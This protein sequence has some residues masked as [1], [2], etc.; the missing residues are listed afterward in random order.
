MSSIMFI[1]ANDLFRSPTNPRKHFDERQLEELASTIRKVGILQ[2]LLVRKNDDGYEV[3]FGSRRY[4]AGI[5][6]GLEVFPCRVVEMTDEQVLEAQAIENLQRSDLQPLEEADS[7]KTLLE[8]PE[9]DVPAIAAKVGKSESYI[10]Q[11]LKLLELCDEGRTYLEDEVITVSHAIMLARLQP[12]DQKAALEHIVYSDW[13]VPN[14]KLCKNVR[15]LE[16][17]LENNVYLNLHE[18]AF[19]KE[20]E[21][22]NPN[23]GP[24]TTCQKRTG[25]APALFPDIQDGDTCTDRVCFKKKFDAH[26]KAKE[27][28]LA[29]KG[30]VVKISDS[31]YVTDAQKRKGILSGLEY[32]PAG[33]KKC[34]STV[35]ALIVDG[36]EKGSTKRVCTD[37][38]C[39]V[40]GQ[41]AKPIFEETLSEDDRAKAA[42]EEFEHKLERLTRQR[43]LGQLLDRRQNEDIGLDFDE[44]RVVALSVM[45]E[46]YGGEE[47]QL[48]AL[49]FKVNDAGNGFVDKDGKPYT[50][51]GAFAKFLIFTALEGQTSSYGEATEL[52]YL[53]EQQQIDIKAIRKKAR[54]E[55]KAEGK[56]EQ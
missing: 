34:P 12:K 2:P 35:T 24:C 47:E 15:E 54:A 38:K 36:Q 43:I 46:M 42:K 3:I 49:G 37:K 1:D 50:L 9:Y 41:G 6:A 52:L 32:N 10:Y 56:A 45:S 22:L 33:K 27:A 51:P 11:R 19:D 16:Y 31:Y 20:S 44:V 14:A 23:A 7:Y 39:E 17:W 21:T 28:Q 55:L 29:E 18:A 13:R 25:A 8:R 5:M 30:E 40:H 26:M 4:R 53:A 48:E